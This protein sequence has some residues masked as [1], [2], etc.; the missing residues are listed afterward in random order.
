MDI[1][2]LSAGIARMVNLIAFDV[3]DVASLTYSR[4]ADPL[5]VTATWRVVAP[6]AEALHTPLRRAIRAQVIDGGALP[7]KIEV[8]SRLSVTIYLKTLRPPAYRD[9]DSPQSD[10]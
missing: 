3:C 5:K 7:G 9:G 1:D 2:Q 10:L 6:I 4:D 8:G